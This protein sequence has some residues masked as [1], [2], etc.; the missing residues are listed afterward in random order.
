MTDYQFRQ[1][2]GELKKTNKLLKEINAGMKLMNSQLAYRNKTGD[3]SK[4]LLLLMARR[5][6][7]KDSDMV[8]PWGYTE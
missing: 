2:F 7:V 8:D 5:A 4:N 1:L 6:G 3:E